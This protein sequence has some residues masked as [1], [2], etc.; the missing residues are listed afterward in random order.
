M[1]Q[2]TYSVYIIAMGLAL[3]SISCTS[4]SQRAE[5]L[6]PSTEAKIVAQEQKASYVTEISFATGSSKLSDSAKLKLDETL[7][8][9][10]QA[11]TIDDI[12]VIAWADHEYP[13][14]AK[15]K[16]SKRQVALAGGRGEVITNYFKPLTPASI[17][18]YNMADRPNALENLFSSPDARI[19]RSLESAGIATTA[20]NFETSRERIEGDDHG[21]SQRVGDSSGRDLFKATKRSVIWNGLCT[22][23]SQSTHDK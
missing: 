22:K 14:K 16:L 20:H 23:D 11:G 4:A 8:R 21:D 3:F 13:S 1:K 15:K 7:N 12:K 9:A 2:S 6:P 18:N 10:R 17:D 5:S 19:K